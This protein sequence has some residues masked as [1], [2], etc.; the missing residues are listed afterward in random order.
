MLQQLLLLADAAA[1]ALL[2]LAALP[3]VLAEA[4]AAALLAPG[5]RPPVLAE[6]AAATLP[7]EVALPPVRTA[8]WHIRPDT[9]QRAARPYATN[10]REG[11][12]GTF[13]RTAWLEPGVL[14]WHIS[15]FIFWQRLVT[16]KRK[17]RD[18]P[19]SLRERRGQR[20]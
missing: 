9:R 16:L 11:K 13:F 12:H 2:A 3:P 17:K 10:A 7:A 6:A 4:A 14:R 1:A 15:L 18:I 19:S 5:A 8:G 20:Q